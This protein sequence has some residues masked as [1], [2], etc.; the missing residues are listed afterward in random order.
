MTY[1]PPKIYFNGHI[2]TIL[3]ALLRKV[4]EVD[5]RRE[6]ITTKDGDFLDIDW[7]K[8]DSKTAV[9]ISHG[10]EGDSQ[11]P[12]IKGMARAFSNEEFDVLAWNYRGCSGEMNRK[13]RFYHSGATD[14]LQEV[15]DHAL[16]LG[17]ERIFLIGFS[18]GGNIT[19]KYLGEQG[20]N[21]HSRINGA[22][23]FSVPLNLHSSCITISQPS[24]FIYSKRFL[25]NLKDKIRSKA[26][27]MPEELDTTKLNE[28]KTLIAFDDNYTAPI[29][30]FKSAI[31]YYESCSSLHF[32]NDIKIP[33]L[34]VNALND[35]FLSDDCYPEQEMRQHQYVTLET[36]LRGG[37]VGF[38]S[39]NPE[40]MY[41]SELRAL[42]FVREL[43]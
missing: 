15:V 35:P 33:T 25:I 10:L 31:H 42:A 14:D 4:N 13:L 16:R 23:A 37:H 17:Y 8:N 20:S 9:I 32:L 41:W 34:V 24:N 18:L 21:I 40:K 43:I 3:P 12:Y 30:G 7:L 5:Y 38:T 36:P 39:F 26:E 1:Q 11:R 19:L 29:H 2:E 27:I 22:V 6:R 28:I